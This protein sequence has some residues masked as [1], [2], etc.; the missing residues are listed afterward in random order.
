MIRRSG[1]SAAKPQQIR[2]FRKFRFG[3]FKIEIL[4]RQVAK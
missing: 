2:G 4:S 1:S 3:R